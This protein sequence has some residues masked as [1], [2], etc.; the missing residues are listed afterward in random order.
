M[1]KNLILLDVYL[2]DKCAEEATSDGIPLQANNLADLG[3]QSS[4]AQDKSP[5]HL[6]HSPTSAPLS[7]QKLISDNLPPVSILTAD[8]PA[9]S[10][11]PPLNYNSYQT[12]FNIPIPEGLNDG[13]R[14]RSPP[15]ISRKI[16]NS[17]TSL[18][19]THTPGTNFPAPRGCQPLHTPEKSKPDKSNDVGGFSESSRPHS[20][21]IKIPSVPP[22]H[23]NPPKSAKTN[24]NH[25]DHPQI[26]RSPGVTP[27]APNNPHF[28]DD[29][30]I[31]NL[32]GT[33]PS[34]KHP[35]PTLLTS[36][37]RPTSTPSPM[38]HK[39]DQISSNKPILDDPK[40]V[41]VLM[42]SRT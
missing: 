38:K 21:S 11:S 1:L 33:S 18:S 35:P 6:I 22:S 19:P 30:Q 7:L 3:T 12:S 27:Q 32:D 40:E 9:P 34:T 20:K 8:T 4:F 39:S 24:T 17:P 23:H 15:R 36:D 10:P 41:S 5:P 13:T 28:P 14:Q 31:E 25:N 16:N 42:W 26:G 37:T 2:N 29:A